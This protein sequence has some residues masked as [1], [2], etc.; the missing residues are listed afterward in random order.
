[1]FQLKDEKKSK[2][3]SASELSEL[4]DESTFESTFFNKEDNNTYGHF[5]SIIREIKDGEEGSHLVKIRPPLFYLNGVLSNLSRL[6]SGTGTR[7]ILDNKRW[8]EKELEHLENLHPDVK[9]DETPFDNAFLIEKIDGKVAY[10]ILRDENISNKSKIKS[11]KKITKGLYY[12]HKKDLYHG[13]PNTQNCILTDDG[14]VYWID[15]EIEYHP[16]LTMIER[17]AKDLEQLLLSIMGAFEEEG[18]IGMD[19]DELIDLILESYDDKEVK[20]HFVKNPD[21]PAVGP[22]RMLQLS[23]SNMYRFYQSQINL[24]KYINNREYDY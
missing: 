18:D 21:V 13:E 14:D 1:M 12:I 7:K 16:E 15:F 11:I 6:I 9:I 20:S 17:K 22:F 8:R 4:I 10:D 5:S 24:I 3:I 19:D 2:K 23:F